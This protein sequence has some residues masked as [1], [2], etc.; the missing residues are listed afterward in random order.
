MGLFHRLLKWLTLLWVSDDPLLFLRAGL[1]FFYGAHKA[2]FI[3]LCLTKTI[4]SRPSKIKLRVL[5]NLFGVDPLHHAAEFAAGDF[6][7]VVF[8]GIVELV[9]EGLAG[10]VFGH[11]L[12][13]ELSGGD[14]IEDLLHFF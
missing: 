3:R 10:F 5:R 12:A 13:G 14:F 6:D 4:R 11:P 2:S 9:E 8:V 7:G 1:L